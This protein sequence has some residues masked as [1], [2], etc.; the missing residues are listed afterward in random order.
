MKLT[1]FNIDYKAGNTL[2]CI[3]FNS[4]P[5]LNSLNVLITIAEDGFKSN[6]F[7]TNEENRDV[8]YK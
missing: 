1:F 5:C 8:D 3:F 6:I 4:Q 7:S 2:E